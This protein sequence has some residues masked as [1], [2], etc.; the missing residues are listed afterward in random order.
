MFITREADYGIRTVRALASGEKLNIS[1][2]CEKEE[3]PRQF[4]YK[5]LKKL[6]YAGIVSIIRGVNGGYVLNAK[7]DELTLFDI[8]SVID[9]DL[10]I[11]KCIDL[12]YDCERNHG[13]SACRVHGELMRI[14]NIMELELKKTPL[15]KLI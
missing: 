15:S 11:N 4:A 3:I 12:N 8:V 6:S 14:Q 9:R 10:F 2:I 7:P 13:G 5:I 1:A